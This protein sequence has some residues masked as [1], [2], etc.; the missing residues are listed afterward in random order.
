MRTDPLIVERLKGTLSETELHELRLSLVYANRYLNSIY[1]PIDTTK[2]EYE[3]NI[4]PF[5]AWLAIFCE[6][7]N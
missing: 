1:D 7:C 3:K 6:A 5:V 4:K 2:E